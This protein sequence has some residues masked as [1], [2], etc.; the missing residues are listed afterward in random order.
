MIPPA[1]PPVPPFYRMNMNAG[2]QPRAI[3][4]EIHSFAQQFVANLPLEALSGPAPR[5][6]IR[7][8][9]S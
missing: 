7:R 3:L 9:A 4:A 6:A 5:L 1:D 8:P 2:L